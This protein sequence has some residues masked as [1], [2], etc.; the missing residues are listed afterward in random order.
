MTSPLGALVKTIAG[1]FLSVGLLAVSALSGLTSSW[2]T[3]ERGFTLSN[4]LAIPHLLIF[5]FIF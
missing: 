1:R 4:H 2:I 3:G 5:I